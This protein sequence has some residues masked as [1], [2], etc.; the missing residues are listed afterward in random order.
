MWSI[1]ADAAR[2]GA[3]VGRDGAR[4]F[5]LDGRG[6]AGRSPA[7]AVHSTAAGCGLRCKRTGDP[8]RSSLLT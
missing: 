4:H 6:I 8:G 2:E 1:A 7:T 3:S 5:H